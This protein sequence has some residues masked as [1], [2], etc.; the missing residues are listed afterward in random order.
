CA[1]GHKCIE[2]R[3]RCHGNQRY[4]YK[5][6]KCVPCPKGWVMYENLCYYISNHR[7]TWYDAKNYCEYQS[8]RLMTIDT[9]VMIDFSYEF[10]D[11]FYLKDYFH[12]GAFGSKENKWYWFS[13]HK[14]PAGGPWWSKC[15]IPTNYY[16]NYYHYSESC[17]K[18][19]KYGLGSTSCNSVRER[20]ICETDFEFDS[21]SR[22]DHEIRRY[23]YEDT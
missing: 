3:C 16:G 6:G 7:R 4:S 19:S 17:G 23:N 2:G 8:S 18:L 22:I 20:F 21:R 9:R 5:Y 12:V 11:K 13:G 14:I 10:F 15:F 1:N